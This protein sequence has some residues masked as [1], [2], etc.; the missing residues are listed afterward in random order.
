VRWRSSTSRRRR[1]LVDRAALGQA[2]RVLLTQGMRLKMSRTH[3]A[4]AVLVGCGASSNYLYAPDQA[5]H[6]TDGYPASV[7]AVPPEMPQGK[8]EVASFG[9]TEIKPDGANPL[10]TLHVRLAVTNDGDAGPWQLTTSD[11]LV[12]IAGEGK[13]RPIFVNSDLQSLPSVTID[14]RERR[15]LDFYYPLPANIGGED[16]L[17]AFDFLWQVTTPARN[18]A[19]RTRFA[20]LEKEPPATH[21]HVALYSGWGPFW[22]YDPFYPR[23]VFLHHRPIIIRRPHHV[24][25]TRPPVRHYRAIRDHRR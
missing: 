7:T 8:V 15:V 13:S 2:R 1:P 6:W 20:R 17:P 14:Q 9:I 19:S 11:Q 24:I 4:L 18:F 5:S 10:R 12:E 25:V 23:V 21:T 22:W 3:V 16:A